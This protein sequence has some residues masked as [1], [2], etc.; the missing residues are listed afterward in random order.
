MTLV[1]GK[2]GGQN[3][4]RTVPVLKGTDANP[5]TAQMMPEHGS[6]PKMKCTSLTPTHM[7]TAPSPTSQTYSPEEGFPDGAGDMALAQALTHCGAWSKSGLSGIHLHPV[8]R[9]AATE[10]C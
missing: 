7:P 1:L 4:D 10:N 3:P 8:T 9:R 6:V 2:G 5:W